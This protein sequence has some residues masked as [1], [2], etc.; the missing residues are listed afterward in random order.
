[1]SKSIH[2]EM[3]EVDENDK[4]DT[5]DLDV[6]QGD[7]VGHVGGASGGVH[8]HNWYLK[9]I[10]HFRYCRCHSCKDDD[11]NVKN[12]RELSQPQKRFA[13]KFKRNQE[14]MI[15]FRSFVFHYFLI[16]IL[17]FCYLGAHAKFE[18]LIKN[19]NL[20]LI[21]LKFRGKPFLGLAQLSKI[22]FTL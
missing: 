22:L 8:R 7:C 13:P 11:K 21:P 4:I 18:T 12:L 1:M 2:L 16:E 10:Q 20:F 3:I 14:K 9:S 15:V 19:G 5:V 17:I 6:Y